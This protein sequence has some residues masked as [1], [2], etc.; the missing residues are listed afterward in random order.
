[1]SD[2]G[3]SERLAKLKG[4]W[5]EATSNPDS[6]S[7]EAKR[8]CLE[9]LDAVCKSLGGL[10]EGLA[11]ASEVE[12]QAMEKA[13]ASGDV[14]SHLARL[15]EINQELKAMG[16]VKKS[17]SLYEVLPSHLV[18][19][20]E[21]L[22]KLAEHMGQITL[23]ENDLA[24]WSVSS[25]DNTAVIHHF[26]QIPPFGQMQSYAFGQ[27]RSGAM[28]FNENKE[29]LMHEILTKRHALHVLL[30]HYK[31]VDMELLQTQLNKLN[32]ERESLVYKLRVAEC[33]GYLTDFD[34]F[35]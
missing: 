22:H 11:K 9:E 16:A 18:D 28:P 17:H 8:Q 6:M 10:K 1:M 19:K 23:L 25:V 5:E 31:P 34:P 4:K 3:F 12:T 7:A 24:K 2:E 29:R 35:I 26:G 20:E 13:A 33:Q 32:K 21:H 14:D 27:V 15:R 30:L